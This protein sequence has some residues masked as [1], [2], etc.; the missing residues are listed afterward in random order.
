MS[1]LPP[2][3]SLHLRTTRRV[4]NEMTETEP[5]PRFETYRWRES[6]LAYRPCAPR[7][8]GMKPILRNRCVST[9]Q[10]PPAVMSAT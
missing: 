8:V 5:S 3:G 7:P 1:G 6:R 10:T 9:S 4:W 2:P